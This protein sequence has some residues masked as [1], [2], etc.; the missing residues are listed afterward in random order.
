MPRARN[1]E[2]ETS[3]LLKIDKETEQWLMRRM[4]RRHIRCCNRAIEDIV[5]QCRMKGG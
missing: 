5:Q 2:K 3:I 1:N 4:A